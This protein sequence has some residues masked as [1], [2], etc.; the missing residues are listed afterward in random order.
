MEPDRTTDSPETT[1]LLNQ[2]SA[3]YSTPL[4]SRNLWSPFCLR[5]LALSLFACVYLKVAIALSLLAWYSSKHQGICRVHPTDHYFWQYAPTAAF[6]LMSTLWAQV[7]YRA[8]LMMPWILMAHEAQIADRSVLLDY[9]SPNIVTAL[10]KS[11]KGQDFQV[12]LALSGTLLNKLL[13]IV[14]TGLFTYASVN[15]TL[16]PTATE[17]GRTFSSSGF[18]TSLIRQLPVARVFGI[19]SLNMSYPFG[20]TELYASEIP[21]SRTGNSTVDNSAQVNIFSAYA[22]CEIAHLL[23]EPSYMAVDA[24]MYQYDEPDGSEVEVYDGGGYDIT[25]AQGNTHIYTVLPYLVASGESVGSVL[26][27]ANLSSKSCSFISAHGSELGLPHPIADTSPGLT[28]NDSDYR[29][30]FGLLFSDDQSPFLVCKPGYKLQTANMTYLYHVSPEAGRWAI[31]DLYNDRSLDA[32]TTQNIS[33]AFFTTIKGINKTQVLGSLAPDGDSRSLHD[34]DVLKETFTNLYESTTAQIANRHLLTNSH[35]ECKVMETQAQNRLQLR[36][37]AFWITEVTLMSLTVISVALSHVFKP[38]VTSR[39]PGSITGIATIL[40]RSEGLADSLHD[41]GLTTLKT[42]HHTFS[43]DRF[44]TKAIATSSNPTEAFGIHRDTISDAEKAETALGK[45]SNVTWYYPFIVTALGRLCIIVVAVLI[46]ATL[47]AVYLFSSRHDGFATFTNYQ[48]KEYAWRLIPA[49]VLVLYGLFYSALDFEL[50]TFQPFL[51]LKR[52]SAKGSTSIN[53]NYLGLVGFHG[54]LTAARRKHCCLVATFMGTLSTQ[55][56]TIIVAGLFTAQNAVRE[57]PIQLQ[58]LDHFDMGTFSDVDRVNYQ[59]TGMMAATLVLDE[60]MDLPRWTYDS[61]VIPAMGIPTH[62]SHQNSYQTISITVPATRAVANCTQIQPSKVSFSNSTNA[63]IVYFDSIS[64][65]GN[66][67]IK[68]ITIDSTVIQEIVPGEF[69]FWNDRSGDIYHCPEYLVV[70]GNMKHTNSSWKPLA[71]YCEP[72][73]ETLDASI[74]L[75]Y[76]DLFQVRTSTPILDESTRR[77]ATTAEIPGIGNNLFAPYTTNSETLSKNIVGTYDTVFDYKIQLPNNVTVDGFFGTILEQGTPITALTTNISQLASAVE[78]MY[79]RVVAQVMNLNRVTAP[80]PIPRNGTARLA[81]QLR[82]TQN[83]VPTRILQALLAVMALSTAATFALGS[84]EH[85]LPKNP[86]SIAAVA[87]LLAGS[88]VLEAR[89]IP[90]G[91]EWCG[92]RELERLGL[93]KGLRFSMGWWGNSDADERGQ[94]ERERFG[95]DVGIA[96]WH[97]VRNE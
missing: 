74:E 83:A 46:I 58:Q 60:R 91:S 14:S 90:P 80:D 23:S 20:T 7:D 87:S 54:L 29:F 31:G 17:G 65:C 79:P 69:A 40:A 61:L 66:G 78:D 30:V 1:G 94:G 49:T 71:L 64:P 9:I 42:L 43:G 2:P 37:Y 10:A 13:I 18:N 6:T 47:E 11:V 59:T 22:D 96:E 76:P 36:G 82:L 56:L 41:S 32:L 77:F 34:P 50:K 75:T 44:H 97:E 28:C 92:D 51:D 48:Y 26:I 19:E 21:P 84:L 89:V 68:P 81:N 52:G 53:E 70:A 67:S 8:R 33:D 35:E 27:D 95:I 25:D 72:Y 38:S 63:T 86:R 3:V 4:E 5:R 45:Q 39:D 55:F 57:R 12:A 24:G 93:F 16:A 15:V 88:S 62:L 85:V 73:I